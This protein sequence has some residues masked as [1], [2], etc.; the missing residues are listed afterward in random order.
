MM[1]IVGI[2]HNYRWLPDWT[3]FWTKH[4]FCNSTAVQVFPFNV[5][6]DLLIECLIT[7]ALAS[8]RRIH[9]AISGS[10]RR[11]RLVLVHFLRVFNGRELL[12]TMIANGGQPD[13]FLVSEHTV[14]KFWSFFVLSLQALRGQTRTLAISRGHS[15]ARLPLPAFLVLTLFWFFLGIRTVNSTFVRFALLCDRSG[16]MWGPIHKQTTL[17]P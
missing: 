12:T 10:R 13:F 2:L 16:E 1:N 15:I 3:H 17:P 14:W 11:A 6:S 7:G 5:H 4:R 8:N 9:Y